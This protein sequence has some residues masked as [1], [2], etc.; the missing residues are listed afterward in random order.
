MGH[1][2][3]PCSGLIV[4]NFVK[5]EETK[6]LEDLLPIYKAYSEYKT[7]TQVPNG[8]NGKYQLFILKHNVCIKGNKYQGKTIQ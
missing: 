7:L 1:C 2:V 3:K 4:T 8:Y 5:N 6:N